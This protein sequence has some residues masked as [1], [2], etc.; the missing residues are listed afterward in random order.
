ML[1]VTD[2]RRF[3]THDG[4]GVRT[5]IFLQGCP[6]RCKWCHNPET[7]S[8]PTDENCKEMS[9]SQIMEIT[10]KD[11]AFYGELGGI[12][13]SGGEPLLHIERCLELLR[14]AKMSGI[15]TA[16]ETAGFFDIA[17][18]YEL[19]ELVDLF[20]WDFKDGN[21]ARH[22]DFVGISNEKIIE[23]LRLA[24]K[25]AK[26]IIL[27]CIMVK[28]VNMD[29]ENFSAISQVYASLENCTGV[30]LL[31]YHPYG[32]AKNKQLGRGDNGRTDWI[33]SPD[34]LR[35]GNEALRRLGVKL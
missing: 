16:V 20:L 35:A 14:E 30:E 18:I 17:H 28:G 26:Q 12:T 13:L 4:P 2:I 9:V 15:S 27:R 25:T 5:V 10:L 29:D 22:T 24:D 11:Q 34:D 21:V 31:P 33:P 32:G 1:P 6:L 7:Q 8:M 3:C 19:T 23:N